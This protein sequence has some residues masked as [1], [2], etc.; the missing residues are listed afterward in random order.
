[1]IDVRK[2]LF[3]YRL[4]HFQDPIV[5]IYIGLEGRHKELCKRV[6]Q[7][8]HYSIHS[9]KE[10]ER[11]FQ[12]LLNAKNQRKGNSIEAALHPIIVNLV[13]VKG[14]DIYVGQIWDAI[15]ETIPGIRDEKR[16]I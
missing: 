13:S 8:F 10:I 3:V 6:L 11:A 1:L 2:L 15:L 7:L 12:I 14:K 16:P 5:D 9:I 4:I